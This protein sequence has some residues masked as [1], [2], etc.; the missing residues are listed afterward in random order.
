MLE[1]CRA[2]LEFPEAAVCALSSL[3]IF[4]SIFS[5]VFVLVQSIAAL[6]GFKLASLFQMN[7][8]WRRSP[9]NGQ[10]GKHPTKGFSLSARK[11]YADKN[12]FRPICENPP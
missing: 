9:S 11:V 5:F 2:V 12:E 4:F 8:M 3:L 10:P 6:L 7:D 1:F